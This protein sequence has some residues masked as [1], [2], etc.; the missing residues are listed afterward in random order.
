MITSVTAPVALLRAAVLTGPAAITAADAWL[1]SADL[2]RLPSEQYS[3]LPL[4]LPAIEQAAPDHPWLPR[5]RGI[6]RRAWYANQLTLRAAGRLSQALD[7][8]AIPVMLADALPLALSVYADRPR[9]IGALSFIV[10]CDRAE[11]ACRALAHQG[12]RDTL[13]AA[14]A[15]CGRSVWASSRRFRSIEGLIADLHWRAASFWPSDAADAAA[16]ARAR[17]IAVAGCSI[18]AVSA[19][20]QLARSC[21]LAAHPGPAHLIALADVAALMAG[22]DIDWDIV[23]DVAAACHIGRAVSAVCAG[24]DAILELSAPADALAR[25]AARPASP[26]ETPGRVE[27]PAAR[28]ANRSQALAA[29]YTQYRR[30][31][32]ARGLPPRPG[33]FLTFMQARWG[34]MNRRDLVRAITV[35]L[36]RSR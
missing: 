35:R 13:C 31:A 15:G 24:V 8:V 16:W 9:P 36:R 21:W 1:A 14:T 30:T 26:F 29:V 20:D 6:G 3:L 25:L 12:W 22:G 11:E 10:P 7:S 18:Q 23:L 17:W 28:A 34:C 19:A 5:L 4:A 27:I 32:A 33:D 2:D